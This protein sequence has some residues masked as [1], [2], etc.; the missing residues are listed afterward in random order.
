MQ[1]RQLNRGPVNVLPPRLQIAGD[2][3]LVQVTQILRHQHGERL[4]DQLFGGVT[5]DPFRG[6]IDDEYGAVGIDSENCI[7]GRFGN[8]AIMLVTRAQ[9]LS[10]WS[11]L[12]GLL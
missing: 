8:R 3:G 12:D 6:G 1:T 9:Y 11:I 7:C 5:E 10:S 2:A 4:A